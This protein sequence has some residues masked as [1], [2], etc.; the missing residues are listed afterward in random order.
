MMTDWEKQMIRVSHHLPLIIP[1]TT[2]ICGRESTFTIGMRGDEL[3]GD[4]MNINAALANVSQLYLIS[5][6]V[7]SS[8]MHLVIFKTKNEFVIGVVFIL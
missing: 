7:L 6:L 1:M 4:N 3:L 2:E 5:T 8:L